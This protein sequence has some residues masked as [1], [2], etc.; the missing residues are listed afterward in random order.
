[1]DK[2]LG[3]GILTVNAVY[4]SCLKDAIDKAQFEEM[5]KKLTD[6]EK[7]QLDEIPEILKNHVIS[8]TFTL[9]TDEF[10]EAIIKNDENKKKELFNKF[11]SNIE[12]NSKFKEKSLFKKVGYV[13]GKNIKGDSITT[14]SIFETSSDILTDTE[15]QQWKNINEFKTKFTINDFNSN[16]KL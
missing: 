6:L 9:N 12:K 3:I 5:K 2:K 11:I 16:P 8:H 10:L 14:Y 13:S 4:A 7:S 15:K 1:M